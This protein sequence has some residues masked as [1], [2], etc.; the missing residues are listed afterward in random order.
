MNTDK[1]I[2]E[3]MMRSLG[4]F[5]L[6]DY[7]N[8]DLYM[9]QVTTLI[10]EKFSI[11]KRNDDDKQLTKTM[12]NNYAKFKMLPPPEK[13]KYSRDHLI[14]ISMINFYK[15]VLSIN[16]TGTLIK[17]VVDKYFHNDELPLADIASQIVNGMHKLTG[18]DDIIEL[19]KKCMEKFNFDIYDDAEYLQTLAFIT[20][21]SYQAYIRQQLIIK[22]IDNLSDDGTSDE[23]TN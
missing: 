7:P 17:E 5:T 1:N 10:N 11:T 19:Q 16:D 23:D 15:N 3:E 22:L 8:I 21:L 12:I 2:V 9:D 13:K 6:D 18:N 14:V 4:T 20:I